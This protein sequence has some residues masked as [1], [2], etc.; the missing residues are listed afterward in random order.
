MVRFKGRFP[1]E[2]AFKNILSTH[3]EV[4]NNEKTYLSP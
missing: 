1:E 3:Q 2:P 4:I